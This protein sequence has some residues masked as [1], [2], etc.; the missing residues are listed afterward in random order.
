MA[1]LKLTS[2]IFCSLNSLRDFKNV[3]LNGLD[4]AHGF[5]AEI[6][7]IPFRWDKA[8]VHFRIPQR[9]HAPNVTPLRKMQKQSRGAHH[10]RRF[11]RAVGFNECRRH[12]GSYVFT[13]GALRVPD[14][15]PLRKFRKV[16][17]A[18]RKMFCHEAGAAQ[19]ILNAIHNGPRDI[20]C[21]RLDVQKCLPHFEDGCHLNGPRHAT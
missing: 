12:D 15:T 13:H 21:I 8:R 14:M 18:Q 17:A 10:P 11:S 19:S 16:H 2:A 7:Q 1:S 6:S 5:L 9:D 4:G 3:N 20:S